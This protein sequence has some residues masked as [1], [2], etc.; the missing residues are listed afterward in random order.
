MSKS[1]ILVK[2]G[3][4][5]WKNCTVITGFLLTITGSEGATVPIARSESVRESHRPVDVVTG[6]NLAVVTSWRVHIVVGAVR[7]GVQL[8]KVDGRRSLG[9][10]L[11]RGD[12]ALGQGRF[13][14]KDLLLDGVG[15]AVEGDYSVT[16]DFACPAEP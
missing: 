1:A 12:V 15:V 8:R 9:H 3:S 16:G 10:E 2:A 7:R 11:G 6:G 13:E 4:Q 14:G 5:R